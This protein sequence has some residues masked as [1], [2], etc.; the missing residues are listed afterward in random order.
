MAQIKFETTKPKRKWMIIIGIVVIVISAFILLNYLPVE[1]R[2]YRSF[3]TKDRPLVIAH[4]GGEDLAPSNTL[5][6]F[7]LANN[8]GVDAL[9][10]DI[11]I[12]KD[13]QLVTIHDPTVDRTTNGSG[14]VEN[15]TLEELQKLDAGYYFKD[16]EGELSYRGKGLYIPTV[17]EV[18]QTFPDQRMVIEIKDTNSPER[19]EEISEKLWRLIVKYNLEEKVN[20]SSFDQEIIESFQSYAKGRSPVAGGKQEVLKFVLAHKL[21]VRN[22][23]NPSVDVFQIPTSESIFNLA[24]KK[25]IEGAHRRGMEIHYWTIDDKETMRMLIE[26]GADGIITNR[27]DIMIELLEEM[28]Y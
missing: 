7:T 4:Q 6:S 3:Y 23:Y 18:F 19:T 22:L 28:G 2:P 13:G 21:F 16:L 8:L 15:F 24:D 25:L 27:P 26:A 11:H 1:K 17:E 12:T 9:E 5:A 10:F 20:I 14:K